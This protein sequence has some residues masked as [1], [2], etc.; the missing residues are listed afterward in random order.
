VSTSTSPSRTSTIAG[1]AVGLL[2]LGLMA[3][4]AIGLPKTAD[5]DDSTETGSQVELSLPD[6][7]PGGYSAADLPESFAEGD[8]ADQAE[9]IA[10]QQGESTAYGNEVLPDVL[11]HPAV[12]RSYV[13][14][15]S[16]AVF[17]QVFQAEGGAFA[18]N[19][20]TDPEATGGAGGLTMENV[21]GAACIVSYGQ[22]QGQGLGDP[23][24]T[25]CQ[26]SE[27]GLTVQ[28]QSAQVTAEDLAALSHEVLDGY[29]Q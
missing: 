5:A 15:G 11:G 10:K 18:P 19:S 26:L 17:V 3:A 1:V 23:T 28:V 24:S 9:Q 21:D 12:T 27:D 7:L 25:Q 13:A 14:E 4:F 20:L 29:D 22:S 2:L 8:L 16:K 6:T